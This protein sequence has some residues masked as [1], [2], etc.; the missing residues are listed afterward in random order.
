MSSFPLHFELIPYGSASYQEMI[1][2]REKILRIPLGLQFSADELAAEKND[3]HVGTFLL[4]GNQLIACCVLSPIDH[5]TV[6]L[7]Q[8][9][10]ETAFQRQKI[11]TALL[12][13]AEQIARSKGFQTIVLHARVYAMA[14]YQKH[15]YTVTG[16]EFTEV[17][18]PHVKMKKDIRHGTLQPQ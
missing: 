4:P 5:Q 2:L 15:G 9:A 13:Y 10:V 8:M 3:W 16:D 18:I 17:T 1:R 7:R 6:R 12:Q 14:F 11:G